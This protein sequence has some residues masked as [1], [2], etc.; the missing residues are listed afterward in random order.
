RIRAAVVR[1][2]LD[3]IEKLAEEGGEP[4][5]RFVRDFGN[6]LKEGIIEDPEHRER[7]AGLLRFAS[8]ESPQPR[9]VALG[10]AAERARERVDTEEAG[11]IW[12]LVADSLEQARTSP[13]L[14]AFRAAGV[15]V[16]LLGDPI[17]AW[18]VNHLDEFDG[19]AL[20][21][22]ASGEFQGPGRGEEDTTD[23]EAESELAA[24]ISEALG[25]RVGEVRVSRR[26][27]ESAACI[28]EPTDGMTL[29]MRRMLRQAGQEVP[30]AAPD[31]EVNPGHALVRRLRGEDDPDRFRALAEVL[32]DQAL[33]V[34][35]GELADP[36]GFVRRVNR[37][38]AGEAE[39]GAD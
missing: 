28:A 5:D 10:G 31:L 1:R 4:W 19:V 3:M 20:K 27:T 2:G 24:R 18:L 38:L 22:A 17:D 14:E 30:E 39:P 23:R 12:Y 6:V 7:I 8:T 36:A 33:L 32:L 21:S 25:E 15:E 9:S 16:L 26:L 11:A 29:Q 37:L 13:H 34:Q 35:G